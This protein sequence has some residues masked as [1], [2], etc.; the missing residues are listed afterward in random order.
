[1]FRLFVLSLLCLSN[2]AFADFDLGK[3]ARREP[4]ESY[5]SYK[6]VASLLSVPQS[7]LSSGGT[8]V[9]LAKQYGSSELPKAVEWESEVEMVKR[10]SE[11]RDYRWMSDQ[12]RPDFLR[13]IT[14]LYP[15]DGCYARAGL[16]IRNLHQWNFK[17]PNKIFIF[18]DLVVKTPYASPGSVSWWYHVA[19]IVEVQGQKYVLDPAIEGSEPLKLE[20]WLARH[21][22]D[23]TKLE[24][25]ICASGSYTPYDACARE[26]DGVEST[27]AAD[28]IPFLS[29]EWVRILS[30]GKNPEE[31][32]GD[33]PPWKRD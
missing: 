13:R 30:L 1:M 23:I 26:T 2:F 6:A 19:P 8:P 21:T 17:A 25:A 24:V 31:E 27:A 4:G 28:Q 20:A 12:Q 7:P 14:W 9:D 32:L 33:N 5:R 22:D 15:D 16:A 29:Q 18:G 3:S 11:M 10:F